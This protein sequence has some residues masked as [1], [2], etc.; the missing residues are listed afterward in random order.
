MKAHFGKSFSTKIKLMK[1]KID[2]GA[3]GTF[4][5]P[6]GCTQSGFYNGKIK[7]HNKSLDL[8]A[9]AIKIFPNTILYILRREVISN[10]PSMIFG[11]YS[12]AKEK[13]SNRGGTFIGSF[14]SFYNCFT[15][16]NQIY[17]LLNEFHSSLIENENNISNAVLQ[18]SHSS[19]F[20]VKLPKDFEKLNENLNP[21][22]GTEFFSNTIS[23]NQNFV[24][25]T[26]ETT[27]D[28]I[29]KFFQNSIEFFPNSETIYF[30]QS[31][32]I[33]E[34]VNEKGL[35]K[36]IRFNEFE[37]EI[38]NI[39]IKKVEEQK[40]IEEQKQEVQRKIEEQKRIEDQKREEQ[41][42]I[43]EQIKKDLEERNRIFSKKDNFQHQLK[44]EQQKEIL[45]DYNKLLDWYNDLEKKNAMIKQSNTLSNKDYSHKNQ[46]KENK[47]NSNTKKM[48]FYIIIPTACILLVLSNIYLFF[49]EKPK[50]VYRELT[51]ETTNSKEGQFINLNPFPNSELNQSDKKTLFL[52]PIKGKKIGE[53]VNLIF[54][55]N[56]TEISKIYLFQKKDYQN[57][58]LKLNQNYFKINNDTICINDSIPKIPSFKYSI[59]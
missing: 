28:K 35:L 54:E 56:P 51:V 38:E 29:V 23:Q 47:Q 49:A 46:W 27:E 52:I 1:D 40:R 55:N 50:I 57:N 36:I 37:K 19:E 21:L 48:F 24:V 45:N 15:N 4:G 34:F 58:L 42:K 59:N 7:T 18:V 33:A 32:D 41:R 22:S 16:A 10:E 26:E 13:N 53:I 44:F 2:I 20:K 31:R 25:Y 6:N 8:N 39:N 5:L 43:D 17:S 14:I 9:N 30:S 12:F 11:K 3:I